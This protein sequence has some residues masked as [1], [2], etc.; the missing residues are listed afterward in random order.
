MPFFAFLLAAPNRTKAEKRNK[1]TFSK[2]Q[3]YL[4][5]G[6][7]STSNSGHVSDLWHRTEVVR[8]D[9]SQKTCMAENYP[10]QW[11]NK[12]EKK[13]VSLPRPS[14]RRRRSK[15]SV[16]SCIYCIVCT[17]YTK[18]LDE[19][20]GRLQRRLPRP[21]FSYFGTASLLLL[22]VTGKARTNKTQRA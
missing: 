3:M 18:G 13:N 16:Y 20:V 6:I 11:G 12:A 17:D 9:A 21:P 4:I 1:L 15:P 22:I 5:F 14:L 8:K 2:P 7:T 10:S 19:C